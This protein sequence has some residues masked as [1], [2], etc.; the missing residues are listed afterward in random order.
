M[1]GFIKSYPPQNNSGEKIEKNLTAEIAESAVKDPGLNKKE[2][3]MDFRIIILFLC[4][5]CG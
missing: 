3:K 2:S 4:D 1:L 5:L